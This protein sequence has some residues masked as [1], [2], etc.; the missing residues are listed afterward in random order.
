[1]ATLPK[2]LPPTKKTL[3]SS[4]RQPRLAVKG[5]PRYREPIAASKA[6]AHLLALIDQVHA[7]RTPII[8]TK[9]GRPVVQLVPIEETARPSIFGC[10]KGTFR[11]TGDIVGPE[12]DVWEAMS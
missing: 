6:K 5:M 7:D 9:R 4:G 8:I 12:P 2:S 3:S 10:M 1:M 11:V